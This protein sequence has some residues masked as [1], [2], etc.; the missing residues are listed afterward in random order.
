MDF[1]TNVEEI[2]ELPGAYVLAVELSQPLTVTLGN[3]QER[4]RLWML[5]R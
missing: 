5:D 2:P 3:R 4:E 1:W